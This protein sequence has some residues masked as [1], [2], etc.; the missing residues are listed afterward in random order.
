MLR[1]VIAPTRSYTKA[2]NE[3]LYSRRMNSDAKVLILIVQSL[4]EKE[5]YEALGKYA[6]AL[7][8][9]PREYRNARKHLIANGYLHEWRWQN[10]RGRWV[11]DQLASNVTLTS[12]EAIA[13]RGGG[14]PPESP[15]ER[16]PKAGSSRDRN[17]RTYKPVDKDSGKNDPH[18]PPKARAEREPDPDPDPQPDPAPEAD[19]EADPAPPDGDP[20]FLTAERLLLSLRHSHKDLLLGVREARGLAEQAAE[21]LRRGIPAADLRRALTAYLPGTGVRSAVGFLRHRLTEKMPAPLVPDVPEAP[22]EP[23]ARPAP[24]IACEGPG[25]PHVFRP[26]VDETRCGPCRREAAWEEHEQ[27]HGLPRSRPDDKPVPWRERFDRYAEGAV[28]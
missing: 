4:P 28:T 27:R 19:I 13:L 1:H 18:P 7:E 15:S 5:R 26:A 6:E 16:E 3:I 9:T 22:A 8:L 2:S 21:W 14:E 24:L 23:P 12:E 17:A 10:E 11:T 20:E 25:N